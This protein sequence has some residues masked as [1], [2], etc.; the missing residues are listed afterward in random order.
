MNI[1]KKQQL[2]KQEK[3]KQQEFEA[4]MRV[5]QT[6]NKMKIKSNKFDEFKNSY[7][8]KAKKASL[9]GNKEIYDL[10]KTGLKIC[11]SKQRYLDQMIAN[12]ELSLE[13]SDMNKVVS[14][15][16]EGINILSNQMQTV[17]G[18]VDMSKAQAAY[19]KALMN[20]ES[21][22]EALETFLSEANSSFENMNGVVSPITDEEI[23][24][25]IFTQAADQVDS[26]DAE[27]EHKISRL[28]ER[29]GE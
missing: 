6:L 3:L 8:E 17:S 27:I 25:L 18:G 4:R 29:I 12:F 16:F 21:Q 9:E 11:L 10:A 28:K 22:Y 2:K 26:M 7:I 14:E 24:K 20:N 19:E 15:F 1:F 5:K 23:D 13:I